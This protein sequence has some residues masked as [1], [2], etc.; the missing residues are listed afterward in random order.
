MSGPTAHHGTR[1]PAS[2]RAVK[3][4]NVIQTLYQALSERISTEKDSHGTG[5]SERT[6]PNARHSPF[7]IVNSSRGGVRAEACRPPGTAEAL[8]LASE[9]ASPLACAPLND[10]TFCL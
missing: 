10:L 4:F 3:P 6:M 7:F 1:F 9:G 2:R 8:G 5:F